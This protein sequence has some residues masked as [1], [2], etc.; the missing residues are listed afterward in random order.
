M[1]RVSFENISSGFKWKK[2]YI[3]YSH[4]CKSDF[5]EAVDLLQVSR[6]SKLSLIGAV[7]LP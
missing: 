4:I 6:W 5:K 3:W 2:N 1:F 7:K